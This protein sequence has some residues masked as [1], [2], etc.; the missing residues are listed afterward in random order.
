MCSRDPANQPRTR[1]PSTQAIIWKEKENS[2][3]R[4]VQMDN[5]RGLVGIRRMDKVPN[6]M[7][8]ALCEVTKWVDEMI[9]EGDLRWFGYVGRMENDRVAKRVLYVGLCAGSRSVGRPRKR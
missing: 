3:I 6:A 1:H 9:D 2:R 8:R 5:L 7:I 4:T